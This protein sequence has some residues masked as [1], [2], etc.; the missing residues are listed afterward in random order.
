MSTSSFKVTPAILTSQAT[1][2][3]NLNGRYKTAIAQLDNSELSLNGMWEGE[4]KEAF[5]TAFNNDKI[6]MEEFYK[7]VAQYV[8]KLISIANRYKQTEQTN[9][10][11]AK[12][13]NY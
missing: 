2:L 3:N 5:H 12:T 7:L 10:E 4:A 9:T 6:K 11:T 1:E 8:E 13:R